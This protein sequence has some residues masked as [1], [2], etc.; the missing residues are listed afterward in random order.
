MAETNGSNTPPPNRVAENGP[1]PGA[2]ASATAE[3]AAAATEP[4]RVER[5]EEM[6]DKIAT[7]VSDFTSR[8]GRRVMR[9]LSRVKEEA[10]DMWGEAQSIRRGD[11]P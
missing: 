7:G 3:P 9:L 2:T 1:P 8:W 6:V 4:S 5:A 11:Q 10:E